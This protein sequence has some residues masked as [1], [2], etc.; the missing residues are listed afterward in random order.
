MT[1]KFDAIN[2]DEDTIILFS[3]DATLHE[4]NV[5]YEKWNFDGITAESIIF[6]SEDVKHLDDEAVQAVVKTS[7]LVNEDSTLTFSRKDGGYTYVNFNFV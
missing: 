6:L 7:P 1:N 4:Y 3:T 2:V 5:R